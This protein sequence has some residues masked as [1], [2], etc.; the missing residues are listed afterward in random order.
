MASTGQRDPYE[1]LGVAR[2]A[3]DA[4]IKKA[5]RRLARELHPDV[6]RHDPDAE[7]KFKE[8]A[9][10]YEILSDGERRSGL[11]PL[12]PRG[13]AHRRD[14]PELRG[15][16]LD[17]RPL[18]RVLRRRLRRRARDRPGAGRRRRRGRRGHARA[19]RDRRV[20][21]P[22]VRGDRRLRALPRQR[23]RAR[24]RRS[25]PARAAAATASCRRCRARPSGRS[26][27]RWP[28]TSAAA[29]ARS[30]RCPASAATAAA[31]RSGAGTWPS[32]CRRASPTASA[33]AWPAAATRASAAARPATSTS[34][35]RSQDDE[36]FLRDGDDLVTVLDVPAPMAALGATLEVP[37]LDGP[38]E[39]EVHEGTQPGEV[40]TLRGR[41]MPAC[42]GRAGA[43]TCR[44]SST[45]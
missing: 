37:T 40:L 29:T 24:A 9:E 15:L 6:N 4:T 11:R 8:A 44:S 13:A 3:D 26:S 33:S 41:G 1:I 12:R 39:V 10:A 2:D 21:R 45:S 28:A 20:R 42:A 38:A 31:A 14:G 17:Q 18:R 27:A 16:R 30:P 22:V 25:R 35:S 32:T 36:R 5:F 34:W 19:G 23:R 7:E 43:A